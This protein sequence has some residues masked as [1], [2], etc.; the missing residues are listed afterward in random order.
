MPVRR[1]AKT[2]CSTVVQAASKHEA[3]VV[4]RITG[5]CPLVDAELVD[6]CI[7]NFSIPMPNIA[8]IRIRQPTLMVSISR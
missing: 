2:M 6:A 1:K 8:V 4:V 3:D 5:D 7:A